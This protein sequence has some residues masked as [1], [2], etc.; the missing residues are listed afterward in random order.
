MSDT[1]D[2]SDSPDLVEQ[3]KAV[4]AEDDRGPFTTSIPNKFHKLS[5]DSVI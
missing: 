4:L 3:A 5:L 1:A 2:K